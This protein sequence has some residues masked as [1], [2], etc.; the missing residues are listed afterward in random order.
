VT[1]LTYD[2]WPGTL[3]PASGSPDRRPGSVRRTTSI[4]MLPSGGME[5]GMVLVGRGRDLRT[6][7]DGTATAAD[8][9]T[10]TART[11][12]F[13]RVVSSIVVEP[14]LAGT[15]L[16]VGTSIMGG[17]RKALG[18][19]VGMTSGSLTELLLDDLTGA[20]IASGSTMIRTRIELAGEAPAPM[21][22]AQEGRPSPCIGH[23]AGGV[24]DTRGREGRPLL[25][26]GPPA[27]ALTRDD[28][29]LAWH[30]EP[31]LPV[32][33]MR[34][35]RRLDVWREGDRVLV[36]AHFRDSR[37]VAGEFE[38][39]VHE[40]E[41]GVELD[42]ADLTVLRI[43]V[44]PRSLPGPECAGAAAS[45]QRVVG[46]RA[47]DIRQLARGVLRGDTTCTHLNDQLRS[48]ADIPALV[49]RLG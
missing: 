20:S 26:Q 1:Y 38:S 35:R 15:D 8:T 16:L 5:D 34:R 21:P 28:D 14:A 44:R 23:I 31:V 42:G 30:D 25:G 11:E 39:A 45:A 10:V 29:P 33:A 27:P 3:G 43:E 40:Y 36:D 24:M 46:A 41:L 19:A 37:M 32:Y 17:F 6:D 7:L 4:D 13:G 9:A 22:L 47:G 2:A 18:D 48:L 49:A 12:G